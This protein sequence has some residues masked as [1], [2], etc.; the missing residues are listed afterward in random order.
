M[1]A[2]AVSNTGMQVAIA[3]TSRKCINVAPDHGIAL[4]ELISVLDAAA[5]P[6]DARCE[7]GALELHSRAAAR[8]GS[9]CPDQRRDAA[10]ERHRNGLHKGL[11][12]EHRPTYEP[13]IL[14]GHKSVGS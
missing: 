5:M 14:C 9:D 13:V 7:L 10:D 1:K 12:A 3:G 6:F 8:V 4:F 2:T 11:P